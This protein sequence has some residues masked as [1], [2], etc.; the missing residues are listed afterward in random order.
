MGQAVEDMKRARRPAFDTALGDEFNRYTMLADSLINDAINEHLEWLRPF[1]KGRA[2]RFK[3]I[4]K[5]NLQ[6][7]ACEALIAKYLR[8][9]LDIVYPFED[10]SSGGP[11]FRCTQAGRDFY[12]EVTSL[13]TN[14]VEDACSIPD[15]PNWQGGAVGSISGILRSSISDKVHQCTREDVPTLIAVGILHSW[16]SDGVDRRLV[17]DMLISDVAYEPSVSP[18]HA[19]PNQLGEFVTSLRNSLFM[20]VGD[21]GVAIKRKPVSGVVVFGLGVHPPRV[22]GVTNGNAHRPFDPDLLP[23]IEFAEAMVRDNRVGIRW[24]IRNGT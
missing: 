2:E 14:A 9:C 17:Q 22:I 12:V 6:G 23:Q 21:N 19:K 13:A 8:D 16:A 5:I 11:D 18:A 3:R 7:A 20:A 4:Q 24:H 10:P 15:D 1:D